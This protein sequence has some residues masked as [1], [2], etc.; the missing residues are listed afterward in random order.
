MVGVDESELEKSFSGA[1]NLYVVIAAAIVGVT[2]AM[3]VMI[4]E[5]V[6][7]VGLGSKVMVGVPSSSDPFSFWLLDLSS[8]CFIGCLKKGVTSIGFDADDTEEGEFDFEEDAK[9]NR[10][11]AAND[12][13]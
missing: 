3:G 8:T 6:G 4:G 10:V 7:V 9:C 2:N 5:T 11:G 1:L 13:V 12:D